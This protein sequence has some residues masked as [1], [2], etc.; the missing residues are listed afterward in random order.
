MARQITDLPAATNIVDADRFLLRQGAISKQVPYSVIKASTNSLIDAKIG[1]KLSITTTT[2][3]NDGLD[4]DTLISNGV[5]RVINPTSTVAV[6]PALTDIYIEVFVTDGNN[7]LQQITDVV[8]NLS[9]T[10]VKV[11]GVFSELL[12][13]GDS[14][15]VLVTG[16]GVLKENKNYIIGDS[17]VYTLPSTS[18]L[19][20]KD[21][22]NVLKISTATS[23][24]IQVNGGAGEVIKLYDPVSG[25]LRASDTSVNYNIYSG[26]SFIFNTD[27][28]L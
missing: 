28:E 14:S 24:T 12:Q 1:S 9:Y 22:I 3:D 11:A 27:W 8:N 17:S 23:P 15:Y 13:Q 19:V 25:T 16:G 18:G 21:T 2:E 6:L 7:L 4:I 20:L 5:Y 10:R 26:I